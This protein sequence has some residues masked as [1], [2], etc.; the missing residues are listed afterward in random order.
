MID[1]GNLTASLCNFPPLEVNEEKI[2]L[3]DEECVSYSLATDVLNDGDLF[4]PDLN[5][6]FEGVACDPEDQHLAQEKE[7]MLFGS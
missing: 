4:N 1:E 6:G 2:C 5:R 7:P 3:E